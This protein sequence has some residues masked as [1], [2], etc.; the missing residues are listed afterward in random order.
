M[1]FVRN[2]AFPSVEE[3]VHLAQDGNFDQMPVEPKDVRTGFREFGEPVASVRGKMTNV[4]VKSSVRSDKEL[5]EKRKNQVLVID[6]VTILKQLFL[7][8]LA[9]PLELILSYYLSDQKAATLAQGIAAMLATLRSRAFNCLEILCDP[10]SGLVSLEY[11]FP[12]VTFDIAGANDHLPKLDIKIRRLKETCRCVKADLVWQ[13]PDFLVPSLVRYSNTRL[14][15]RR[16]KGVNTNVCARVRFNGLKVNYRR[17]YG[18]AFGDYVEARNAKA[19]SN[20]VE[21]ERSVPCI[22]LYPAV[23]YA[24]S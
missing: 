17:E 14:N 20:R 8:G 21:D 19:K 12:G 1:E 22:A 9:S 4:K 23:N 6:V 16:T 3:A 24:S 15:T 13:L 10:Q 2:A 5:I 18:L 11:K 7:V